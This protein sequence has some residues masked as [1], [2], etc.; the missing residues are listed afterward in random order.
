MPAPTVLPAIPLFG[1]KKGLLGKTHPLFAGAV[2]SKALGAVTGAPAGGICQGP[3]C[4]LLPMLSVMNL[5]L[6]DVQVR[7][8]ECVK[9]VR[10]R[11]SWVE[12]GWEQGSLGA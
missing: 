4:A 9:G 2:A 5:T 8:V 10:G 11:E 12:G 1:L 7:T 3:V 6:A